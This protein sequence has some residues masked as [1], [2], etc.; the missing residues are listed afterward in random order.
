MLYCF[1]IQH[2]V[3]SSSARLALNDDSMCSCRYDYLN[4]STSIWLPC[5]QAGKLH[6]LRSLSS[7]TVWR[8]NK[9]TTT[10]HLFP[11]VS[12]NRKKIRVII[13]RLQLKRSPY[14]LTSFNIVNKK[15]EVAVRDTFI[16]TKTAVMMHVM[17]A[18]TIH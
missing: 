16:I 15:A 10:E 8:T 12:V 7:S 6:Q 17:D 4:V 9:A 5:K 1:R 2:N 14:R 11:V 3:L 13:S 18:Y